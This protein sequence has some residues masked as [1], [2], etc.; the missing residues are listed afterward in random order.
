MSLLRSKLFIALVSL[1]VFT[2]FAHELLGDCCAEPGAVEQTHDC[3][4][5]CHSALAP[6]TCE[7]PCLPMASHIVV[8]AFQPGDLFAPQAD[9]RAI[10]H[11][12]QLG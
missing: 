10:D 11:P 2:G 8:E 1:F 7:P 3:P 9:P 4:C 12:P 6:V 5:L